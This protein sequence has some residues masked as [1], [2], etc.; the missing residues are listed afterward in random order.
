[1][2]WIKSVNTGPG[3]AG[4]LMWRMLPLIIICTLTHPIVGIDVNDSSKTVKL[5]KYDR[6][7]ILQ[8][9]GPETIIYTQQ[10]FYKVQSN[11]LLCR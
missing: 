2:G 9:K 10:G 5:N 7:Q 11:K 6:I 8:I 4:A 1:M 3:R